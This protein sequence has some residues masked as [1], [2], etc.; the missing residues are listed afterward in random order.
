[1][2]ASFF[3]LN[4]HNKFQC[5]KQINFPGICAPDDQVQFSKKKKK[6]KTKGGHNSNENVMQPVQKCII[7][8]TCGQSTERIKSTSYAKKCVHM[9]M[10]RKDE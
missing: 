10:L 8:S 2:F 7:T 6:K 1:M 5:P 9:T 3:I 4:I